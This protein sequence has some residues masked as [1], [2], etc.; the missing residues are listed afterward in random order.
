MSVL[1]GEFLYLI[2]L[3]DGAVKVGQTRLIR[4]R[5]QTHRRSHG[6]LAWV[7]L[8]P[9]HNRLE[10]AVKS[11]FGEIGLRRGSTEVYDGRTREQAVAAV[12]AEILASVNWKAKAAAEQIER[13]L[14][15][16]FSLVEE[17]PEEAARFV[18][19]LSGKQPVAA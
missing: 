9:G 3:P 6:G 17:Y 12:R 2:G 4:Q 16:L 13:D 1:Q 18:R 7:H 5:I 11:R 19:E 14:D 8:F 10:Y 15:E